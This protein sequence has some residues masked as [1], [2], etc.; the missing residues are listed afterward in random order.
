MRKT[1]F[2]Y[3][4]EVIFESGFNSDL[5]KFN[6]IGIGENLTE[7]PSELI[8][9]FYD[10]EDKNKKVDI[11]NGWVLTN[12]GIQYMLKKGIVKMIRIKENGIKS[13]SVFDK[14]DIEKL[15]GKP[16]RISDESITWVWDS[17][18]YAKIYHYK[19]R[20]IKVHFSTENGKVCELE[21]E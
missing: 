18:T 11:K 14:N 16:S 12:N 20:K 7:L 8:S 17:V 1:E 21:I 5:L 13:L 15:I 10:E 4:P 9:E 2:T 19:K 6:G 3:N